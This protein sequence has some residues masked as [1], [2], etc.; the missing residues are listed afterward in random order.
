VAATGVISFGYALFSVALLSTLFVVGDGQIVLLAV[1]ATWICAD[2]VVTI[3]CGWLLGRARRADVAVAIEPVQVIGA[4]ELLRSGLLHALSQVGSSLADRGV[5]LLALSGGYAATAQA[6][7]AQSMAAPVLLPVGALAA[8]IMAEACGATSKSY[9]RISR[10]VSALICALGLFL[11]PRFAG[12]VFGEQ[13]SPIGRHVWLLMAGAACLAFWKTGHLQLR[14]RR[15]PGYAATSNLCAL[16]VA[17]MSLLL[18]LN[19]GSITSVLLLLAIY[20]AA[21]AVSVWAMNCLTDEPT[22][23]SRLSA[24]F[25]TGTGRLPRARRA[26]GAA[27]VEPAPP[28]DGVVA[29]R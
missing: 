19:L 1:V 3:A 27:G 20:G 15:R 6:S 24:V 7:V 22:Q 2:L 12:T 23:N 25:A 26:S 8:P 28:A 11:I 4:R 10:A 9:A 13:Y 29:Q 17:G 16:A 21:G 18:W 5:M 14:G